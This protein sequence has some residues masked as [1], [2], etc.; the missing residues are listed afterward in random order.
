MG[1]LLAL[2]THYAWHPD[3]A[4]ADR[5][6]RHFGLLARH[7]A[8]DAPL[9]ALCTRLFLHWLGPLDTQDQPEGEAWITAHDAPLQT[10]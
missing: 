10:Q 3:L 2:L 8:V 1:G 4:A 9:R 6:A 5:I 7:P